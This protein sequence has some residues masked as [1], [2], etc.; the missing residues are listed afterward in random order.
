MVE[1]DLGLRRFTPSAERLL[2]LIPSDVGRPLGDLRTNLE[3]PDLAKT[4]RGVIDSLV[5]VDRVVKDR[6]G[7][8]YLLR[9]RPYLT[10]ERKIDGAVIILTDLAALKAS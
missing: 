3:A 2:N 6:E 4:V 10:R 5:S 9:V 1:A 8:A 7:R